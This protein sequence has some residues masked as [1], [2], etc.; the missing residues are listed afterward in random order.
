MLDIKSICSYIRGIIHGANAGR[1]GSKKTNLDKCDAA[2]LDKPNLS[3]IYDGNWRKD[4]R[5][6]ALSAQKHGEVTYGAMGYAAPFFEEIGKCPRCY[7]SR[8][9]EGACV[10]L[11]KI[12]KL[13]RE[14]I[15][16]RMRGLIPI[17]AEQE[18][19]LARGFRLE[20][21]TGAVKAPQGPVN[22]PRPEFEVHI[23]GKQ[24]DVEA[25]VLM[26]SDKVRQLD[27]IT[28]QLGENFWI[29][30]T[31]V[32]Y[33]ERVKNK[34]KEKLVKSAKDTGLIV[35]LNQYAKF[36]HPI[37]VINLIR[38]IALDPQVLH[39]CDWQYPLAISYVY[40]YFVQGFWFNLSIAQRI[41]ISE[42][43][44]EQIRS[45]V[46][47]SFWPRPDGVFLHEGMSDNEHIKEL[48]KI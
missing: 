43:T 24:I 21:G 15:V 33:V 12:S 4:L 10:L 25:T 11:P 23:D 47:N 29:S 9:E 7:Q 1:Q 48:S 28:R 32:D 42:Q 37:D 8:L 18:L 39:I 22:K 17:S 20:F 36:L 19:L 34:I 30:C 5:K 35:V 2:L 40:Q 41:G 44:K 27:C 26:D 31:E 6:K 13:E 45:A 38:R 3:S 14:H 16:K 46:K